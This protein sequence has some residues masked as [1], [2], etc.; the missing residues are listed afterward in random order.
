M[1]TKVLHWTVLTRDAEI[2]PA[3]SKAEIPLFVTRPK[4]P[5]T[6][7]C[8]LWCWHQHL[9]LVSAEKS[10][11]NLVC[12]PSLSQSFHSSVDKARNL[13]R[14]LTSVTLWTQW[15]GVELT[16]RT[17]GFSC[18]VW[19]VLQVPENS[20]NGPHL[21]AVYSALCNYPCA[22]SSLCGWYR[23]ICC[24]FLCGPLRQFTQHLLILDIYGLR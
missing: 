22:T 4:L 24:W 19:S 7:W 3:S 8:Y 6:C 14:L 20:M 17:Q 23:I 10:S 1:K 21:G 5:G 13:I 9:R 2:P 15:N 18:E 12:F 16:Y 11:C